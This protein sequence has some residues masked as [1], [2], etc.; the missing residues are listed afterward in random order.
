MLDQL[1]KNMLSQAVHRSNLLNLIVKAQKRRQDKNILSG[2]RN[3]HA[4][5]G[6]ERTLEFKD[7]RKIKLGNTEKNYF[8][9]FNPHSATRT[10]PC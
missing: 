6:Q 1:V 10:L 8:N 9:A 3:T 5:K 2:L 7:R 4:E